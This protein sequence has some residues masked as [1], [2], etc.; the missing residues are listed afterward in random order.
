VLL[1]VAWLIVPRVTPVVL[2]WLSTG[3][4]LAV[5]VWETTRA[6]RQRA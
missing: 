2:S 1:C 3:M 6:R 5:G 4:L